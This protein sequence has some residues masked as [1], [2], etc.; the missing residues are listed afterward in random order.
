MVPSGVF[1]H[2]LHH[3]GERR[4]DLLTREMGVGHPSGEGPVEGPEEGEG[5]GRAEG[6]ADTRMT[7]SALIG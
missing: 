6:G 3:D 7:S 1:G 5:V 4:E 2:K